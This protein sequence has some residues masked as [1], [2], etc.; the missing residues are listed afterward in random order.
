MFGNMADEFIHERKESLN[1][2]LNRIAKIPI[3]ADSAAFQ[4]FVSR[5]FTFDEGMSEIDAEVKKLT[6]SSITKSIEK[7][8]PEVCRKENPQNAEQ[9]L[10]VMMEFLTNEEETLTNL[11]KES[12]E[13]VACL[14]KSISALGRVNTALGGLYNLEKAFSGPNADSR[15][16]VLH[17]LNQYH[18]DQKESDPSYYNDIVITITNE[19]YDVQ[20]MIQILKRQAS[21][22]TEYYKRTLPRAEGW[23]VKEPKGDKEILAKEKDTRTEEEEKKWLAVFNNMLLNDQFKSMWSEKLKDWKLALTRF[24]SAQYVY[25]KKSTDNF[26][27][28]KDG[29]S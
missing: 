3:L 29:S 13:L 18:V 12:K 26:S 19:L 24:G 11:I 7:F 23:L 2:F 14:S 28:I 4:M 16:D 8:F 21:L 27:E 9:D 5:A 20:N 15:Y 25:C 1:R 17:N 10:K 6:V 22:S